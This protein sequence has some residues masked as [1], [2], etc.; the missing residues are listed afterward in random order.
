MGPI[1]SRKDRKI[2]LDDQSSQPPELQGILFTDA[3]PKCLRREN[4]RSSCVNK[5][6]SVEKQW[7]H[8]NTVGKYMFLKIWS[9]N[10]SGLMILSGSCISGLP[11]RAS[12]TE[13]K[14]K[15]ILR[16]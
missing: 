3:R 16:K 9:K 6:G 13:I 12:I 8:K 14:A 1:F 10:G 5:I 7:L 15:L 11:F 4:Q 2:P